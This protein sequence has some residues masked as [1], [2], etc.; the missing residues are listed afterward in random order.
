MTDSTKG[1]QACFDDL[2]LNAITALYSIYDREIAA[3][4]AG[5]VS[6]ARHLFSNREKLMAL[7]L[8]MRRAEIVFALSDQPIAAQHGVLKSVS[9][10]LKNSIDNLKDINGARKGSDQAVKVL[11][12]LS[13]RLR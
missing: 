12:N 6:L 7:F 2:K 3:R 8:E 9:L 1:T 10:S 13:E 4:D 11:T 5:S